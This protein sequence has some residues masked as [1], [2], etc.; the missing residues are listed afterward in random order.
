[1]HCILANR[2]VGPKFTTF[3]VFVSSSET[4]G[5]IVGA[6]RSKLNGRRNRCWTQVNNWLWAAPVFSYS[7]LRV[8]LKIRTHESWGEA[9]RDEQVV[10]IFFAPFSEDYKKWQGQ[11]HH[12]GAEGGGLPSNW[13]LGMC[14]WMGSQK[15]HLIYPKWTKM[16]SLTGHKIDQK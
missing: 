8:E 16:G 13:L 9:A 6:M 3:T 4:Q 1:M 2:H 14:R 12:P 10:H 11:P 15:S 5:L 7:P